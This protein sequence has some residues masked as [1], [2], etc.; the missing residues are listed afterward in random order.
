MI[1]KIIKTLDKY[2]ANISPCYKE[3]SSWGDIKE[4]FF[5]DWLKRSIIDSFIFNFIKIQDVMG[6]KFFKAV[7]DNLEEYK[8]N[9]SFIDVVNKLE[10]LELIKDAQSW[11]NYRNLRNNLTHEYP[12]NYD[13]VIDNLQK[14]LMAYKNI[15]EI[16]LNIKQ[17]YKK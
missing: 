3:I 13:E 8:S 1:D 17:S 5:D 2:F 15:K 10:K 7:L 9:M 12:G 6:D 16:Y 11:R 4:D 14:A